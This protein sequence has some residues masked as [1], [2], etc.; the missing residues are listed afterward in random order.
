[1][2][3]SVVIA[4]HDRCQALRALLAVLFRQDLAPADFEVIVVVDGSADGTTAMLQSIRAP[5]ALRWLEQPNAGQAAARNAGW[6]VATAPLVLFLDDDLECAS[7]LLHRH[8]AAHDGVDDRVAV[9]RVRSVPEARRAFAQ[10][11]IAEQLED[12]AVRLKDQAQMTWPRDAYVATNCSVPVALLRRVGGFDPDFFRALEDHDLGLRLWASGAA[13][14]YLHDAVVTQRY[15]KSTADTVRDEQWY[16]RA[17]VLLGRKHPDCLQHTLLARI[18][19]QQGWRRHLLRWFARWPRLA[20]LC[21]ACP[22]MVL[23]RLDATERF[24]VPGRR[25]AAVWMHAERLRAGVAA[26]GGWAA[27]DA[28][29]ARRLAVLM[30]HHVGPAVPGTYPDL[31]VTPEAFE[32]QIA[33]LASRGYVTISPADYVRVRR[34]AATLPPR[35]VMVTFDDGYADL[36]QYALP[37][38][39]KH[40][41]GAV[42]FV[43]TGELS[44]TNSWDEVRG[45]AT[46]RLLGPDDILAWRR[47]GIDFGGHSR[48]H[49]SLPDLDDARLAAEVAGCRGDLR[50]LTGVDPVAFAYPYGDL[51]DRVVATAEQEFAL[52]FT[53]DEG[54]NG[55]GTDARR[56]RRTMVMPRDSAL[57]VLWRARL[58]FGPRDVLLRWRAVLVRPV[59]AARD[60]FVRGAAASR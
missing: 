11:T 56:L 6:Q 1:M 33:R 47:L 60:R 44:G 28:T 30:Y 31:T 34:G 46:H 37:V 5:C 40:R 13:F 16:G 22:V 23:E 43:V 50:T 54:L 2:K 18:A 48:T 8:L 19:S 7:D 25:L 52:A 41:Y 58:G 3:L 20:W 36:V 12:W 42:V 29:F 27:F 4:T 45:S 59:R 9:G 14:V 39:A 24:A 21:V 17:D 53:T 35:A 26:S 38:L 57:D 49:A 32:R 10:D 51:D 55:L 15:A